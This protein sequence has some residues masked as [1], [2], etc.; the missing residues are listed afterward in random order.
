ML[1]FAQGA[2]FFTQIDLKWGYHQVELKPESRYIT[3][4]VT[5]CGTFQNKR[6]LFGAV[7]AAEDFQ[8]I[9]SQCFAGLKNVINKSNNI[10]L[11]GKTQEEHASC[12]E[13][14]LSRM[15]ECGLTARIDK[16]EFCQEKI[17]FF[18]Y[19][20][21]AEGIKPTH[22]KVQALQSCKMPL[23]VKEL[24]IFLGL[25]GWVLLRFAP[26]YSTLVEPLS[27]LTRK[28]AQWKWGIR[29]QNAYKQIMSLLERQ[30]KLHHF[31]P[32]LETRVYADASPVELGALLCQKD[33]S[34]IERTVQCIS[35]TLSDVERRYSQTEREALA[36]VW[37]CEKLHMFLY[38]GKFTL[39][40]DHEALLC[41]HGNS[42]KNPPAR[43]LRWAIRLQGYDFH[44]E[45]IQ[46]HK[47]PADVLSRCPQRLSDPETDMVEQSIKQ[48]IAH[49][50][51][52]AISLQE[53]IL[54]SVQDELITKVIS[55]IEKNLWDKCLDLKPFWEVRH[56]LSCKNGL[57][58]RRER[59]VIP[60]PLR[61]NVLSIAHEVHLGITITKALLRSKV[62][63]PG[64]DGQV[65]TLIS[66]CDLC[67]VVGGRSP[68]KEPL[69]PTKLPSNPWEQLHID[70]YGPLPDGNSIIG[71]IDETSHWP[72]V[73]VVRRCTTA[74]VIK[75]LQT[76]FSSWGLPK[77]V[78]SDNGSQF[79]CYA[80]RSYLKSL[81]IQ[82]RLVT[83]Y[84][85]RANGEIEQFFRNLGKS[86]NISVLQG[87]DYKEE[88]LTLLQS[89][90]MA[91][92]CTTGLSPADLML[93]FKP[94]GKIP[95]VEKAL[96]GSKIKQARI[97]DSKQK[98]AMKARYDTKHHTKLSVLK[99]GDTVVQIQDRRNKFC[100]AFQM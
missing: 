67:Q 25:A 53:V 79:T 11:F 20:V 83:P 39:I 37:A 41:I 80:F 90:R 91:P 6:L 74:N 47:N 94:T 62:W 63:W 27:C 43:I 18:G 40:T 65:E 5:H 64:I 84:W 93:G 26:Q 19:E 73:V 87:K 1:Q 78:V 13:A 15:E 52:K 29:Q 46:G 92:H 32:S 45:Y 85:R 96:R 95:S 48:I 44:V 77:G 86:I 38:G 35:R 71:I 76:L 10:L 36:L 97:N 99:P 50:V 17:Q 16:C 4:F 42:R 51:P 60:G 100:D 12:L 88:I 2:L 54:E 8:K 24:H 61:K 66:N 82:H 98:S 3:A 72:Q 31:D 28:G 7:N 89:Y 49:A 81:G 55:A 34:G 58:L 21:S 23:N 14:L 69:N 75:C 68:H 9:M 33:K 22:E 56:E 57:L 30:L 59:L 70:I